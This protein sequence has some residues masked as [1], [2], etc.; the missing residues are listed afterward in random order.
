[1]LLISIL[2]PVLGAVALFIWRPRDVRACHA[3]TMTAT[4]ATSACVAWCIFTPGGHPITL[5]KLSDLLSIS[6]KLDGLGRVFGGLVAFLWPLSTLYAFEYMAHEGGENHFFGFYL[7]SYAVTLGIAFAEDLITL[8]I[9]YELLT[10]ATL[11]LVMHGMKPQAVYAGRKYVYYSLGGAAMAFLALATVMYFSGNSNFVAG[12]IPAL[13]SAPMD[14]LLP[15]FVLGFLGFGVKAAIFPF[16]DWL[17][18]ASVAPTPVTA[19]LHAVA[20]VKA[21]AFAVIRLSHYCFSPD[22][23]RG[24]WAQTVCLIVAMF[25][26]VFGS[27]MAVRER[28]MKRRL[29]YS[30]M[31]AS[32]R[33]RS[34]RSLLHTTP[35]SRRREETITS[36]KVALMSASF[37]PSAA[38]PIAIHSNSR[39]SRTN[40][41]SRVVPCPEDN[42]RLS[43]YSIR[44]S[45][46]PAT[47]IRSRDGSAFSSGS[48]GTGEGSPKNPTLA[49]PPHSEGIPMGVPA[50]AGGYPIPDGGYPPLG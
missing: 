30:T 17:P 9:F 7:L 47:R 42:R 16:H 49:A 4:L 2:L 27:A 5:L 6:F 14:L 35:K 22:L 26:I 23:M 31:M 21:G 19:L 18:A 28:H 33:F 8:Y 46:R 1:M 24:T 3:L 43:K 37:P 32:R 44:V 15:M 45:G 25:S 20:V 41:T 38:S 36:R 50:G 10:L 40:A 48:C 29:A 39:T 13:K 11:F 34:V 12:G